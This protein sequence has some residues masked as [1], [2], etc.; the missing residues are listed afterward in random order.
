VYQ[1]VVDARAAEWVVAGLRG[2]GESVLS[3]V[4]A[5]FSEYLRVFHPP[6]SPN[7]WWPQDHAWC[8]A[9]DVDLKTTCIGA[10]RSCAQ[11]LI[12]LPG[13]EAA[14]VSPTLGIDWLSDALNPRQTSA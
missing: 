6:R 10:D 12:S 8:V 3:L 9:T 14:L 2:F 1:A 13:V 5:C 7:L 4:P 11:E